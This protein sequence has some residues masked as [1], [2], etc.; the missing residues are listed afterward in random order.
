MLFLKLF[1]LTIFFTLIILSSR[2]FFSFIL[3]YVLFIFYAFICPLSSRVVFLF[4][5]FTF[6]LLYFYMFL[7]VPNKYLQYVCI[8]FGAFGTCLF[9]RFRAYKICIS[10][11]FLFDFEY[12]LFP[13]FTSKG[14]GGFGRLKQCGSKASR[15]L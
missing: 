11:C 4:R 7:G 10:N 14:C 6:I 15:L 12:I 2:C 13:Q 9:I 8:C 1:F 3:V 5:F